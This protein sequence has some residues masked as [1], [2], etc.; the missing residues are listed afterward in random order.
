MLASS[1]GKASAVPLSAK[2][3]LDRRMMPTSA[4]NFYLNVQV[5]ADEPHQT[6]IL[7]RAS[8]CGESFWLA[9][10]EAFQLLSRGGAHFD[11]KRFKK[12][13][14]LFDV[15]VPTGSRGPPT[16]M[17]KPTLEIEEKGQ[18]QGCCSAG[19]RRASCRARFLQVRP[20]RLREAQGRRGRA[21]L[22]QEGTH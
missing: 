5:L 10:M 2:L 14:E 8:V 18:G 7:T 11:H 16:D 20:G 19:L 3:A 6:A 22:Y 15:R 1:S 4:H 17:P 13:V 9:A 21:A 12:D